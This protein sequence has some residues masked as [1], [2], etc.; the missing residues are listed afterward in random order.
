MF[1]TNKIILI[2]DMHVKKSDIPECQSFIQW[3]SY[4]AQ[5]QKATLMFL[6][7]QYNDFGIADVEVQEFW[8]TAYDHVN[9]VGVNSIS[10]VGNHDANQ[11]NTASFM[12]VHDKQTLVIGRE[13]IK[14]SASIF[15]VGFIRKEDEFYTKV[16]KAY[17]EGARLVIC[18]AEFNGCQYENGF[19]APHGFDLSKYPADLQFLSGH[20]HLKQGFGNVT[21]P[22]SPRHLTRSDIGSIKG[23]HVWNLVDGLM[24]FVQTPETV[25]E[26]FQSIVITE[27]SYDAKLIK[28]IANSKK[29]YVEIQGSKEF[30]KKISKTLAENVH[31][32]SVYTTEAKEVKVRE[33]EGVPKSFNRFQQDFF[34]NNVV[35][36]EIEKAVLEKVYQ[37][38][39]SLKLGLT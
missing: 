35:S 34:K 37:A 7:D 15:A 20:I 10:L 11:Q 1:N 31:V 5:T 4:I 24:E 30:S 23:V 21:Y 22:G 9:S 19:Y 16:M 27:S 3:V 14:L 6:G 17:T 18:H 2:G 25:C 32:R 8:K 13:M 36:P 12:T 39:P 33:S 38:C 26:P 28:N 29:V